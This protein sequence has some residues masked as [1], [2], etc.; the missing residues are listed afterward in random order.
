MNVFL[1]AAPWTED[2]EHRVG[3]VDIP[4]DA[5]PWTPGGGGVTHD[6]AYTTPIESGQFWKSIDIAEPDFEFGTTAGDTYLVVE[7]LASSEVFEEDDL[8]KLRPMYVDLADHDFEDPRDILSF[9][10][11]TPGR[12]SWLPRSKRPMV[13]D[14][15]LPGPGYLTDVATSGPEWL[16]SATR[17]A[18]LSCR[19]TTRLEAEA[20]GLINLNTAPVSVLLALPWMPPKFFEE[21]YI[22][23]VSINDRFELHA[24]IA[25]R[26]V[27]GRSDY[28]YDSSDYKLL[29]EEGED[30]DDDGFIDEGP[31]EE[32]SDLLRVLSDPYLKD[33]IEQILQTFDENYQWTQEEQLDAFSRVS[34]LV[35]TR[36]SVFTIRCRGRITTEQEPEQNITIPGEG[37]LTKQTVIL[38]DQ[39]IIRTIHRK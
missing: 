9:R 4:V 18:A 39:S 16:P 2:D 15:R 10:G 26:I 8:D 28:S 38:A 1:G 17:T 11:G 19:T 33:R 27:E 37:Q 13:R 5:L 3:V 22:S 7:I 21:E 30:D 29:D 32:P 24:A 34:G 35:T 25:H 20:P 23:R 36:S 12:A 14:G 31:Y 6:P